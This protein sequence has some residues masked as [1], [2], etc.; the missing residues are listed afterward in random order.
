V[1]NHGRSRLSLGRW[2]RYDAQGTTGINPHNHPGI[3]PSD[4][5]DNDGQ[6]SVCVAAQRLLMNFGLPWRSR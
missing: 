3:S 4:D 5:L 1:A 2:D 6:G